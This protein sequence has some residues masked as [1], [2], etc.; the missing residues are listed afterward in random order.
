MPLPALSDWGHTRIGL[1]E[2]AQ[3]IGAIRKLDAV[4]LP[5]YLHLALEVV[6]EGLTSGK[7]AKSIGGD[8]LLDYRNAAVVYTAPEEGVSSIPIPAHTQT[9]LMDA[10]L[11]AMAKAGHPA[12]PDRSKI[13]GTDSLR[14]HP[15]MAEEYLEASYSI[16]TALAR[17][18]ARLFGPMSRIVVWPHGFDQSFLWFARGFDEEKDPHMNFGFSPGSAGFER[19]YVYAYARPLPPGFFDIQIPAGARWQ[20]EGWSGIVIDYD[21]LAAEEHIEAALER[22][23]LD[24]HAA[25]APLLV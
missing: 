13:S 4:P 19:P 20:K 11:E 15:G 8:L 3:V 17:F 22:H 6:P 9:T 18:K 2:A 12:N 16:Y 23:L 10:V 5:N 7:L 14:V 24:I 21:T 25:I 1:H